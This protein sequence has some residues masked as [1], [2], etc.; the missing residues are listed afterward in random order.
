[1]SE[2]HDPRRV[3]EE[4]NATVAVGGLIAVIATI[5]VLMLSGTIHF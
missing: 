4:S 2:Q 1:M 5:A 3:P